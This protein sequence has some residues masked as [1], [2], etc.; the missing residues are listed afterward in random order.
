[1]LACRTSSPKSR[2]NPE[3]AA[4]AGRVSSLQR[5][6]SERSEQEGRTLWA[7]FDWVEN[8]GLD[9]TPGYQEALTPFANE[10]QAGDDDHAR[11]ASSGV[12]SLL[13][14]AGADPAHEHGVAL[15]G[16]LVG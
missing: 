8:V 15:R 14:A 12:G 2:K 7:S 16:W 6:L 3:D 5:F 9:E 1:M 4:P 10:Q 13:S 11:E